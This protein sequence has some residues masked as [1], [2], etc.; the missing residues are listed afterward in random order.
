M[1]DIV[2]R[3]DGDIL[4]IM[5]NRPDSGNGATDEMARELK[6]QLDSAHERARIVVL[7]GAGADFCVGRASM[8]ARPAQQ[9]E[10]LDR[11]R[12]SDVIFDAYGAIRN[13]R[14]PVIAAVQGRALGFG[15]AIAA[16]ADMTIAAAD[17]VFQIPEM[18]HRIMPTMVMSALVDRATL[19]G[20]TYLVYSSAEVGPERALAFGL[21]SDI[22]PAAELEDRVTR[23]CA[24][25][26]AC[27]PPATEGAKDYLRRALGMTTPDAVDFAR[28][29]HAVVNSSS[30]M[31]RGGKH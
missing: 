14:L 2:S 31:R 29:I 12:Q 24:K 13:C 19:K 9:P 26:I 22:V 27:P 21:V 3:Q 23:L 17:A 25:I 15:C 16:V 30:E 1:P 8:G 20:L 28:N 10:A 11:R 18:E 4:R 5:L 6:T 7:S